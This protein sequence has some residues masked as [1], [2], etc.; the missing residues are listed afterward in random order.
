MSCVKTL[1]AAL[2]AAPVDKPCTDEAVA[3]LFEAGYDASQQ[4]SP[5]NPATPPAVDLTEACAQ[6]GVPGACM[7]VLAWLAAGL[8]NSLSPD[9]IELAHE[10]AC[11]L[12]GV[13]SRVFSE[14]TLQKLEVPGGPGPRILHTVKRAVKQLAPF[15]K[16]LLPSTSPAV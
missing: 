2:A 12:L 5:K 9:G 7:P 4:L 14:G 10:M 3:V 15:G 16:L 13:V 6:E 11:A 8:R 1:K